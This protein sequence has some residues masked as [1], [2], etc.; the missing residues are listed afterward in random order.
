MIRHPRIEKKS[1]HSFYIVAQLYHLYLVIISSR[2]ASSWFCSGRNHT[3]ISQLN[4]MK[5]YL[6]VITHKS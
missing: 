4:Q 6:T 5:V 2:D 3:D 1:V